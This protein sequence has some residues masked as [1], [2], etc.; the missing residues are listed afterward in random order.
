MLQ[1]SVRKTTTALVLA[2]L[3]G[4]S[5]LAP[6][7][8]QPVHYACDGGK[9]FAVT[10]APNRE[11]AVIDLDGIRFPLRREPSTEGTWSCDVLTLRTEGTSA[12]LDL[13]EG[14]PWSNCREDHR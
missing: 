9:G 13:Q 8:P 6:P 1:L 5:L 14:R 10:F 11:T 4:C 7:P 12:T 3:G 2:G